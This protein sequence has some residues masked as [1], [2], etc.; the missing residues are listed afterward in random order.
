VPA[1]STHEES[2]V[3][4]IGRWT[5]IAFALNLTVGAGILGLPARLQALAGN[6]SI[7][8]I[9]AC[10][11]LMVLIALCFA[12]VGSRFDRTGG[13][14][15]Y[16]SISFG[17]AVGFTV[18]WLLWI[19]R[20]GTCA[21][22][23]NLLVDYATVLLPAAH[24]PLAR[25]GTITA[26]VL[27]YTWINIS[28]IRQTAAVSAAFT[29]SKLVPLAV[30]AFAG[31][32]FIQPERMHLGPLPPLN[33]L[34]TAFLLAGFA[35]FGFDATTVLAGEVRDPRR[36]VPFAIVV[37]I[38]TVMV[39]YSLI[40]LVCVG[41]LPDLVSS[42]RPLADAAT[43]LV[44][45][46]ASVLVA[47][48]AVI[49]CAGVFG[50]S[51]TPGTRLLLA[52]ADREQ[53]PAALKRVNPRYRT[54]VPAILVTAVVALVL[55]VSGSF[56]YLVKITLISR[57]SVYTVTCLTLPFLRR[58]VDLPPAVFRVPAG[59]VIAWGCALVCVLVLAQSSLRELFD[60]T[61][62]VLVG[63]VLFAMTR[64]RLSGR[65]TRAAREATSRT[66]AG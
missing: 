9:V 58:R 53:L 7:A 21:A 44:G 61:L 5:L 26:L 19:S 43:L 55:A 31:L 32:F 1:P 23:S 33:D 6:Y 8:V 25:A 56:I 59:T 54:P 10:G 11:L 4:G 29:L 60:V 64:G 24:Q 30:L 14:Q 49:A 48:T 38:L 28:G 3:R 34:S 2:L 42:E 36:S 27:A 22:V 39:L 46:W 63:L 66:D 37:S 57:V 45:P 40:Q 62:A 50:A 20:L 17:P 52:M 15:L 35:Y 51:M 65:G 18:G 13:P 12:E 16:A 41:T 47:V